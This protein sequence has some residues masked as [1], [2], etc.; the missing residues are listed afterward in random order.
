[1]SA[2]QAI[3]AQK[4]LFRM[5]HDAVSSHPDWV[6]L[7][8]LTRRM[9]CGE[10]DAAVQAAARGFAAAGIEKGDR[11]ALVLPNTPTYVI[12]FYALMSRGAVVVNV[13]PSSQGA[14]LS[15][16]LGDSG[17]VAVVTLDLFLPGLYKV[18]GQSPVQKLFITSLQ[19]LEQKLPRPENVPAP[20][21]FEALFGPSPPV[22][23]VEVGP[24]DL[25]VLQYTS[26]STG[27]P[28]GVML[29]HRNILASVAQT[30]AWMHHE[31]VPNGGVICILPFFH[32]FGMIV[33]LHLSVALG[34]RMILVPRFDALDLMPI[35]E[36]L[37]KERPIS[38][39]AVP[40]L[41]AALVENP[42]VTAKTLSSLLVASSGGAPLPDWVQE[43]YRALTGRLI[44]EAYG[45]SE[46]AG[47]T[48][49]VPFPDGGPAGSIGRPL[50]GLSVRLCDPQT[51]EGEVA[52]GEVGEIALR[53][54]PV[55]SG[56]FR[57]EALSQSALRDGWLHTGDLARRDEDGFFYIVDR[58]DDLILTSG[59]NV[60]PSEVERVLADHPAV[61]EVAVVGKPD[62]MR[63]AVVI[64]HV[65]PR[66][67][68]PVSLDELLAR[69]RDNL[70]D[71]KVP[72]RLYFVDS[73][74]K[75][76]AG[77]TLRKT[78]REAP[79]PI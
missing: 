4:N 78:L 59:H 50:S 7:T 29:S 5:F 54:A 38:L 77:K 27:A 17:A 34:Y 49:C 10:L 79:E 53:G 18:L 74:P 24:E 9:T 32:V 40:T 45:L 52:T 51:G 31:E 41:W 66:P 39:P 8:M 33:G 69:C 67:D 68:V 63:G 13:S 3:A 73:L 43:R 1:M 58:K 48:H 28:K 47:A 75:N 65:V 20:R 70:P 60:Y 2:H 30:A 35:V 15:Q 12:A 57:N 25:A 46:A 37:E 76:P 23:N 61:K 44:Y 14:E 6:A 21:P 22:A 42:R 72:R 26:G 36:L 71:W 56:Y 55:M 11:V 62:R 64:A 16:I 19:G